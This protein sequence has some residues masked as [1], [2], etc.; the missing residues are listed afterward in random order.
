MYD[1]RFRRLIEWVGENPRHW[2][3]LTETLN[4][5]KGRSRLYRLFRD[6]L[7]EGDLK[8]SYMHRLWRLADMQETRIRRSKMNENRTPEEGERVMADVFI[9]KVAEESMGV[10]VSFGTVDG[11]IGCFLLVKQPLIHRVVHRESDI[12][13]VQGLVLGVNKDSWTVKLSV[14]DLSVKMPH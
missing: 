10:R 11:W 1:S 5:R 13:A 3:M 6:L 7:K 14:H 4:Y 8:P 12:F 9:T 2:W